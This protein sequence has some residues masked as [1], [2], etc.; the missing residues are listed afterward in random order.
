MIGSSQILGL[1]GGLVRNVVLDHYRLQVEVV[2]VLLV[3]YLV[4]LLPRYLHCVLFLFIWVTC[5]QRVNRVHSDVVEG[6]YV[7]L[8]V[9]V[10]LQFGV[11]RFCSM[12]VLESVGVII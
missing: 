8:D 12:D 2:I 6:T 7:F 10:E 9:V 1:L 4:Q 5:H 11:L 3:E